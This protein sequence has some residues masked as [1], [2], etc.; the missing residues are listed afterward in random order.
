MFN[1]HN[2]KK[3]RKERR[4]KDVLQTEGSQGTCPE[5]HGAGRMI[6]SLGRC[7]DPLSCFRFL[8]QNTDVSFSFSSGKTPKSNRITGKH[9]CKLPIWWTQETLASLNHR[10]RGGDAKCGAGEACRGHRG[11][12]WPRRAWAAGTHSLFH[13]SPLCPEPHSSLWVNW[14]ST[15][16]AVEGPSVDAAWY[17]FRKQERRS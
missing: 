13:E 3:Q 5:R 15:H 2:G 17:G 6:G 1:H 12:G 9:I 7:N 11:Q 14:E 10:R 16:Q 4:R 8:L